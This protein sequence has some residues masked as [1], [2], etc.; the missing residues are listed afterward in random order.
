MNIENAG[1]V[2]VTVAI[3]TYQRRHY[4]LDALQSVICQETKFAF[5]ILVLD[6]NDKPELKETVLEIAQNST[7]LIRYI[8]IEETGLHNVRNI[9]AIKA[10]GDIICYI[11][12]DVIVPN[13]WLAA[14]CEP[15]N[16]G[17][18]GGV[19][20]KALPKWE[21]SPPKWIYSLPAYYFSLLNLGPISR[22]MNTLET[23]YGCN[24]AYRRE[25]VISLK[26]FSPDGIG[27][28]LI[29]WRRGD[30]E[31]GFARKVHNMGYKILYVPQAFLYH[32]IPE[33]R[34]TI[35]F[36]RRRTIKGAI[37]VSYSEERYSSS[38]RMSLLFRAIKHIIKGILAILSRLATTPK[39]TKFWLKYEIQWIHHII[40]ALYKS[41]LVVD[42]ALRN[43]VH[44]SHYWPEDDQFRSL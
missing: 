40:S 18:V 44:K 35:D 12:D 4:L 25:L 43:W 29:E 30:G 10:Y 26:G 15:F 16:I 37:S 41:R 13:S 23:P 24:M 39:G 11:D 38:S 7:I 3:P 32:R 6:N 27:D 20:G 8:H 5:E 19:G 1:G 42:P 21:S 28:S 31:V 17:E 36:I 22:E 33:Q 14:I 2:R 34:Q 9:A